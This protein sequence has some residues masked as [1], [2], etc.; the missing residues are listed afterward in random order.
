[1]E[2]AFNPEE[3][4]ENIDAKLIYGLEKVSQIYRLLLWQT[5]TETGL[6]PIQSQ[7][8]IFM[9]FHD[10]KLISIS[11][12]AIEFSVTKATVSDAFKTL[13]KKGFVRKEQDISDK[14]RQILKLTEEGIAI[15][16]KI[17][18]YTQPLE[19]GLEA[20]TTKKKEQFFVLLKDLLG[21]LN[22]NGVISPLRMCMT[23]RFYE[24]RE[25]K[26]YCNLMETTLKESEL[27]LDCAEYEGKMK[28]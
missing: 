8:L 21:T 18:T 2:S 25:G 27:R 6:S 19:Q 11:N 24:K 14:R 1:M 26:S 28:E 9:L 22:R 23:C 7:I 16:Q 10:E 4:V 17:K 15:A 20:L 5:Q 12:F 3:Q 13:T